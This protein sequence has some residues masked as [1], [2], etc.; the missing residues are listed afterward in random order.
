[1]IIAALIFLFWWLPG[2]H[3]VFK[4]WYRDFS[5]LQFGDLVMG[6]ILSSIFGGLA[7]PCVLIWTYL[8]QKSIDNDLADRVG[9]VLAGKRTPKPDRYEALLA[10]NAELERELEIERSC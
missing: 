8:S 10:R 3:G 7:G 9:K 1:M 4:L 5:P 2:F 6:I